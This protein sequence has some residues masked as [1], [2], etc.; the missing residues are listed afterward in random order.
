MNQ[1]GRTKGITMPNGDSQAKLISE[2]YCAAGFDP[3][4]TGYVEAHGTGTATGDP[5]EAK[6]LSQVFCR[7][8]MPD[9]PLVIGSVKSNIG[10]LEGASG[11]ASLVK[12]V[13]MLERCQ[14]LPN[15]NFQKPNADIPFA[16]WKLK[17]GSNTMS[18]NFA[19]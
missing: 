15:A 4:N 19:N 17:V 13:L 16:D 14:F 11:L 8:R 1:D 3:L 9:N 5:I 6:A 18:G 7:D 2:M 10:H 12:V